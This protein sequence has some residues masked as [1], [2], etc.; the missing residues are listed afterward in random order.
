MSVCKL[1]FW[2]GMLAIYQEVL[3]LKFSE[4]FSSNVWHPDVRIFEVQDAASNEL[5][6]HFYLDLFPRDGKYTH[7]AC[8][9]LQPGCL[10]DVES[11]QRQYPVAAMV[12]ANI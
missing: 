10:L 9:G 5:V 2:L 1:N 6:G 7:A 11:N 4:V 12:F 8:F 3:G